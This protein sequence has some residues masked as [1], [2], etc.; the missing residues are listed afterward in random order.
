MPMA[1]ASPTFPDPTHQLLQRH[2]FSCVRS[3]PCWR[4]VLKCL[5]CADSHSLGLEEQY[6]YMA[7]VEV[8]EVFR[9]C[10]AS[11]LS[12]HTTDGTHHALRNCQSF[13]RQCNAMLH[14]SLHRTGPSVS[15]SHLCPCIPYTSRLICCAMSCASV[16]STQPL[17]ASSP[18]PF[19]SC[20]S[21][22]PLA[23]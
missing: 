17:S 13:D 23:L 11:M 8:Y 3:A 22:S 21:P 9:F 14:P 6:R 2:H 15:I 1:G 20:T 5:I 10:L 7:E 16:N 18:A 12:N 4:V 19:L